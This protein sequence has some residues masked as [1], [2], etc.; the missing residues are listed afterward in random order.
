MAP[1][2]GF[3]PHNKLPRIEILCVYC[4]KILILPISQKNKRRFCNRQC[5]KLWQKNLSWN[6]KLGIKK[7]TE[8]RNKLSDTTKGRKKSENHKRKIGL[9]NKGNERPDLV[10]YNKKYKSEWMRNYNFKYK[11]DQVKGSKNPNWHDGVS[12]E[13]YGLEFNKELK[14][15]IRKRDNYRCQECHYTEQ[16]LK[17]K[18]DIHH[19]DYDKKNCK[20]NNLISL[21]HSCHPK[22]NFNRESWI[23]YYKNKVIT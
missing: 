1:P 23:E 10:E 7:A 11:S 9:A 18:L 14:E 2:K 5:Q 19:I 20:P 21:C 4:S 3:V 15:E 22:T 12:F 8:I 13:P 17:R 6:D 16:Q